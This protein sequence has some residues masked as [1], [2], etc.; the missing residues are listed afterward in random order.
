MCLTKKCGNSSSGTRS[1]NLGNA[2]TA[3]NI[4]LLRVYSGKCQLG[5]TF[6]IIEGSAWT[7]NGC[8]GKFWICFDHKGEIHPAGPVTTTTTE[9][10]TTTMPTTT[11]TTQIMSTTQRPT[12]PDFTPFDYSDPDDIFYGR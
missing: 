8:E 5:E 6:G 2:F 4:Q 1:C 11:P 10:T 12:T 9:T 3:T 7:S